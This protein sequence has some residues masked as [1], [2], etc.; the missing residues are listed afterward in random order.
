M[1]AL[2]CCRVGLAAAILL[3]LNEVLYQILKTIV[4]IYRI[5]GTIARFF[6]AWKRFACRE[7]LE[8]ALWWRRANGKAAVPLHRVSAMRS[9][10]LMFGSV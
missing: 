9:L 3:A 4:L 1:H 2:A 7:R 8:E 10:K 5:N 6:M